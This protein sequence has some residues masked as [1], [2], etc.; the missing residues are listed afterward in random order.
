MSTFH[1]IRGSH[2]IQGY[3]GS[4]SKGGKIQRERRSRGGLQSKSSLVRQVLYRG[5]IV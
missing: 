3:F 2:P 1:P 5:V 4:M